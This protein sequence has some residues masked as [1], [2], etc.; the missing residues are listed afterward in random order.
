LESRLPLGDA[1]LSALLSSPLLGSNLVVFDLQ[2][3][4]ASNTGSNS[5]SILTNLPY[6]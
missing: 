4:A 6:G 2:P 1:L 3:A 5:V